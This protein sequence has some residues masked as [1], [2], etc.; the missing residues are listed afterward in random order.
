MKCLKE[1]GFNEKD[2]RIIAGPYWDQTTVVRTPTHLLSEFSIKIGVRQGC[3]LSP[4]SICIICKEVIDS[5]GVYIGGMNINNLRYADDTAL[6]T[7][8][9]ADLQT[10]LDKVNACEKQ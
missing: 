7:L 1:I 8:N 9:V 6:I 10:L 4:I 2:L 3:V 5:N